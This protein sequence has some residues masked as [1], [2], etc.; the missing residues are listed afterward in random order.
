MG[1]GGSVSAMLASLKNNKRERKSTFE[2]MKKN[3][4][5]KVNSDKLN[6]KHKA[7]KKEI[8]A[9]RDKIRKENRKRFIMQCLTICITALII[10]LLLSQ[11]KFN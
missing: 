4:T 11:I 3:N 8:L 1:F 2:M 5:G 6:F 10:I 7:S 9:I